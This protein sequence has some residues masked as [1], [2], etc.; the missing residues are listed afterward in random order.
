M[1]DGGGFVASIMGACESNGHELY[2]WACKERINEAR[3][4]MGRASKDFDPIL[5]RR[6]NTC[7]SFAI[8]LGI[9]ELGQTSM[10]CGKTAG[11][12]NHDV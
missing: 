5:R 11:N 7:D 3:F 2:N 9:R 6:R 1:H 8:Y 10:K 12:M 4:Q